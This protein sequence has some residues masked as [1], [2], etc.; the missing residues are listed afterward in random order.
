LAGVRVFASEDVVAAMTY[1][2]E[3]DDVVRAKAQAKAV[4]VNAGSIERFP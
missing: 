2:V 4:R 3:N 1:I